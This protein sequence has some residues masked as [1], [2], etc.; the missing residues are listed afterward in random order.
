MSVN[1]QYGESWGKTNFDRL[2]GTSKQRVLT[3]EG[4]NKIIMDILGSDQ[5]LAA[6]AQGENS[7]GGF[8]STTKSLLAQDL[9]VKIAGELANITA[10]EISTTKEDSTTRKR[11]KN[12]SI[13]G[14][15]KTVICTELN[16]QGLLSDYLYSHP[17]AVAHFQNLS[18]HTLRGYRSWADKCVPIIAAHPALAIALTPVATARYSMIVTGKWNFLGSLTIHIAQP[19]CYAIGKLLAFGDKYGRLKSAA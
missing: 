19:I 13:G 16:R 7:S 9:V 1:G 2:V 18:P 15:T 17:K 11:D 4:M 12:M 14:D 6:L 8:S 10:P 3:Q 5:G